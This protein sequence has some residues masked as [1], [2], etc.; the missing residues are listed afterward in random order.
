MQV[1]NLQL[2]N[3]RCFKDVT[4]SFDSPLVVISGANGTGK[5]SLLEALYY[6]CYARSFRTY[7]AQELIRFNEPSFF[8]KVGFGSDNEH[9]ELHVGFADKK[10]LIKLNQHTVATYKQLL[11]H[12]RVV[13]LTEDELE[14]IKGG[15]EERRRFLD[16]ATLLQDPEHV[17]DL[18]KLRHIVTARNALL[19]QSVVD[20]DSYQVWTQQLK[21]CSTLVQM[22][23]ILLLKD[24]EQIINTLLVQYVS[25]DNSITLEYVPKLYEA[26]LYEREMRFGRSLFGA[27]LDEIVIH[28]QEKKSRVFASR[29]QQKL[30]VVLIKMAQVQLLLDKRGPCLILL[31]DFMTDFDPYHA[32]ALVKALID[33]KCQLLFTAP[34][35]LGSLE[36][37]FYELGAQELKIDSLN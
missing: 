29:G 28:F 8:I 13:T 34:G 15:P 20:E 23:R 1:R 17:S 2:K 33:L 3:F 30:L 9:H 14:L 27:Q 12:Y 5:T 37:F 22:R 36:Q 24:L 19:K 16:Q 21:T 25:P 31:D 10:R 11:D 7:N 18:K 35:Y 32:Q 26:D 4:V 6:A